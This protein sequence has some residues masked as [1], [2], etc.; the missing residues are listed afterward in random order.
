MPGP[1]VIRTT[2]HA[3]VAAEGCT[4]SYIRSNPFFT[5]PF[6]GDL[7][8]RGGQDSRPSSLL[9]RR[10]GA[11]HGSVGEGNYIFFFNPKQEKRSL[12]V[13]RKI[14]MVDVEEIFQ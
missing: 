9:R 11:V 13:Q 8:V 7:N 5:H 1:A 14:R 12:I 2:K 3:V 6:R 10:A 4:I